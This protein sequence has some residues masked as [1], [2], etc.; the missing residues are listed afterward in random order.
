MESAALPAIYRRYLAILGVEA[1]PP[2]LERLGRLVRAQLER[3]PFENLS[4]LYYLR[5]RGLR[6]VPDLSLYLDGIE[7]HGFGGTCYSNNPYLYG[8]LEALG[9][10]VSLC[11]ADMSEPDVHIAL[12]VHL[13]GREYLVDVGYAAPFLAPMPRDLDHDFE[14]SLGEERWVLAPRDEQG[15]SAVHHY[16]AGER[17][18]GYRVKPEPRRPEFFAPIVLD[19]FR[20]GSTFMN[21]A[22]VVSFAD[23]E[24]LQLSDFTLVRSTAT[25]AE[26]I[27]LAG[28]EEVY[29]VIEQRFGIAAEIA[30]VALAGVGPFPAAPA[31]TTAPG[32]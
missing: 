1:G 3:A 2:T 23:G 5:T 26:I 13:D 27:R 18:H 9:Y 19:S 32:W 10:S 20:A 14:V 29:R 22:R 30:R 12:V 6:G 25:G 24:S 4:K 21:R 11:G 8:L 16:R 28:A 31:G 15:R 17:I 7:R